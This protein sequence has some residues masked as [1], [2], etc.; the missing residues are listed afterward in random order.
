MSNCIEWGK[1]KDKDGYGIVQIEGKLMR[2][3]RIEWEKKYGPIPNG[4]WVLHRCD[5]P[6][7]VNLDHLFLGTPKDN[8]QDCLK[9]GRR[10]TPRGFGHYRSKISEETARQIKVLG[11][12]LTLEKISKQFG[13]STA[14]V[15]RI[16]N[17]KWHNVAGL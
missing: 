8:I 11:S 10:N 13:T 9:K 4:G 17:N 15:S 2:A 16:L 3:H 5:N 14:T 6:S 1:W 12:A 7:C